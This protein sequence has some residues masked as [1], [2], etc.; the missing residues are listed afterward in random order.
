[1]AALTT[2]DPA[3]LA[4]LVIKCHRC[5][6][7]RDDCRARLTCINGKVEAN[8]VDDDGALW[9]W[10]PQ[11]GGY[12]SPCRVVSCTPGSADGCFDVDVYHDG[13]FPSD[14]RQVT[15]HFCSTQ[16]LVKF[17]ELVAAHLVAVAAKR[18][19]QS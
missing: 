12:C 5:G 11:V 19:K 16:Q 10:L 17:G 4:R 18:A 14:E 13:E 7:S 1:M 3:E 9:C 15:L 6:E 8:H 2:D